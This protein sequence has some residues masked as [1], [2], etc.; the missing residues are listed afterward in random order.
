MGWENYHEFLGHSVQ[1]V[2]G[3]QKLMSNERGRE[4]IY[5]DR[6]SRAIRLL[7]E[8]I[9]SIEELI[10]L[11]N[12]PLFSQRSVERMLREL[13]TVVRSMRRVERSTPHARTRFWSKEHKALALAMKITKL[14]STS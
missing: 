3:I 8:V 4:V 2:S 14:L 10:A 5:M 11:S 12:P 13:K 1:G 6:Y 9:T 7:E